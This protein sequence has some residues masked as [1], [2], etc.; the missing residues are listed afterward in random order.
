MKGK[1][2]E[3]S[4]EEGKT[5]LRLESTDALSKVVL[6]I[7]R[8]FL[9]DTLT[10]Q[11][12]SSD[13]EGWTGKCPFCSGASNRKKNAYHSYRPAYLTPRQTGYVFHCCACGT[14]LTAF[15][16]LLNA[17]GDQRAQEYAERRWEAGE[18]C[19]GGWNCPLPQRVRERLLDAKEK[20]RE[21][22]R[23]ADQQRK[24]LNYQKKYGSRS[25]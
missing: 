24:V 21:A 17:H 9:E 14:S 4:R 20:R 25:H 12:T 2:Y 1:H 3:Y 15:K 13:G 23:H 22:Y 7:D 10:D 16:F 6:E 8:Q 19:G 5:V 18:L 11:K